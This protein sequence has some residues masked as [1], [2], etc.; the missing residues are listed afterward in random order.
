[1][2][3][4]LTLN[5][6]R[7]VGVKQFQSF[8]TDMWTIKATIADTG[9]LALND[10]LV[11]TMAVPGVALGDIVLFHSFTMDQND[12]TDQALTQVMVTAADVVS[13]YIQADK[14]EFAADAM[15]TAVLK[16][17]VGRLGTDFA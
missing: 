2:A 17:V 3:D 13:L 14:G 12:G 9:A 15:N 11:M 1:M 4:T 7:R 8:F 16:A 5:K 6:Q 10:T